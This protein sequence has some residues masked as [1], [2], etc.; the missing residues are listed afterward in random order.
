MV[1]Q[2]FHFVCYVPSDSSAELISKIRT[3]VRTFLFV[4]LSLYPCRF[5]ILFYLLI[6]VLQYILPWIKTITSNHFELIVSCVLPFPPEFA[7]VGGVW[8]V[9][10]SFSLRQ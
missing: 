7:Q 5:V 3:Q 2:W 1:L 8:Y 10:D 6:G 9:C 4:R